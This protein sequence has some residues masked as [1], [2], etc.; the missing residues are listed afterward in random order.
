MTARSLGKLL[1]LAGLGSTALAGCN[2]PGG[3]SG[4]TGA[5]ANARAWTYAAPAQFAPHP[6]SGVAAR[7]AVGGTNLVAA[8]AVVPVAPPVA[9]AIA[10]GCPAAVKPPLAEPAGPNWA[11]HVAHLAVA[12]SKPIRDPMLQPASAREVAAVNVAPPERPR[13]LPA[14]PVLAPVPAVQ[15]RVAPPAAVTPPTTAGIGHAADY[16]WVCGEVM[17][18]NREWRLRYAAVDEE[19]HYGGSVTLAG[20]E[21]LSQ[22]R[23]GEHYRVRGQLVP[24]DSRTGGP[25]F[26]IE[27]LQAAGH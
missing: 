5:P 12:N 16:S 13:V 3:P 11:A 14:E 22:L 27:A 18:W 9:L 25:V 4:T 23:E 21:F 8:A 2:L 20:E 10:S 7:T 17:H 24:R 1:C 6:G 19:D 26:H 15:P